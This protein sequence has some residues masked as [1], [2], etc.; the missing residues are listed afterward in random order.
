MGLEWIKNE[1]QVLG[2]VIT[3]DYNPAETEFITPDSYKQ[4]LGFIVYPKDGVIAPHIH[5]NVERNLHGTSEVLFVRRGRCQVDFYLDDKSFFCCRELQ[6]GDLVLLV[7][8]GHGFR[9]ME[10]TVLLEIKQGPYAG[11]QDKER[12]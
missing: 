11:V 9:M 1:Q 10:D 12:F 7:G 4:Q 3:S 8:G 5:H 6:T 2:L